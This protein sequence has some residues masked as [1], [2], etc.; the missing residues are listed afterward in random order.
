MRRIDLIV[1]VVYV[2]GVFAL[3]VVCRGRQRNADEYFTGHG[4]FKGSLGIFLVGLSIAASFLSATSIIVLSSSAYTDGIKVLCC[5]LSLALAWAIVRYWFLRRYLTANNRH[6]YDI[7]EAR[8]GYRVRL[9]LSVL[10]F[11]QRIGW[12]A[13]VIYAPTV[14]LMGAMGLGLAWY[15]PVAIAIG[16]TCTVLATI[17]GIRGLIVIDAVQFIAIAVGLLFII[18]AILSRLDLPWNGIIANLSER[19]HLSLFDFS[20]S[21]V[22]PWTFWAVMIGM[23]VESVGRFASD[24][25]SLQRYLASESNAAVF[26]SFVI[27]LW[28]AVA[29]CTLL[30]VAGL[31]L[32]VWY[33]YNPSSARPKDSDQIL[34][35]FAMREL[36]PGLSGLFIAAVVAA[37][38]NTLT[39]GLNSMAGA[40]TTDFIVPL[41]PPR[42]PAQ[43]LRIGRISSIVLGGLATAFAGVAVHLGT[44]LQT[45]QIASA[46]L[47]PML[48]CMVWTISKINLRPKAVLWGMIIGSIAACTVAC[49]AATTFWVIPTGFA[50]A[51]I[52]TWI[53]LGLAWRNRLLRGSI[54]LS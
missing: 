22:K 46:F 29:V 45:S 37:T 21:L 6:P 5:M 41:G 20:P 31:L 7:V 24:Q 14:I 10:F 49:S 34:P 52:I 53:D 26:R 23:T 38:I 44:V 18:G 43:L 1:V 2:V 13:V 40:L 47:G 15:W 17:G 12:M 4:A 25:V 19:G 8:F 36:A 39:S 35:F 32:S 16:L 9:C 33:Q 27:N 3:G 54:E 42:T 48:A 11:L 30:V 28:G 51:M 50:V